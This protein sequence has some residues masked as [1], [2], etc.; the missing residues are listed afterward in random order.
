MKSE[1]TAGICTQCGKPIPV[2]NEIIT[3]G[4]WYNGHEYR[5]DTNGIAHLVDVRCEWHRHWHSEEVSHA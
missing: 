1:V 4:G 3:I 5:L 2:N